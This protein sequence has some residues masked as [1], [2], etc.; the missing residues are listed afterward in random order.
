V[1]TDDFTIRKAKL[2]SVA[3]YRR[4]VGRIVAYF[5]ALGVRAFGTWDEVN[6]AS[7]PT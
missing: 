6:H 5:R 4:Q 7:Q 3:T 1:S 2:P